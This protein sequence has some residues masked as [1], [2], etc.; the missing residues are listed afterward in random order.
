LEIEPSDIYFLTGLPKR[1]DHLTLFGTRPGG[2]SIASLRLEWCNTQNQ[3]KCIEINTIR[4]PE[5]MVIAFTVTR[6]CGAAALHLATGSQ[7][8]MAI[9]CYRGTIFNW[10]DAILANMKGQLTREKNRQLKTFGY[11]PL[12]VSFAL[13]RVPM[14]VPQHLTVEIGA[15]REPKLTRWVTVMAHHPE[16]GA[17][18]V[19]FSPEY[20]HW[21]ENQIF[22]IQDFPYAGVDF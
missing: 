22:V 21:L 3:E 20:F 2:Q 9:D 13:E 15:P 7:M 11:G 12:V 18:V 6:L 19:R 14:L 5:L 10:C 16:E 8:R 4:L 1:G 17:R